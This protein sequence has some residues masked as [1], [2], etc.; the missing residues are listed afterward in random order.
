MANP[1]STFC[2]A[3]TRLMHLEEDYSRKRKPK[4]ERVDEIRTTL[5]NYLDEHKLSCLAVDVTTFDEET[6][7]PVS[8][9][10][11]L[12]ISTPSTIGVLNP[13][14]IEQAVNKVTPEDLRAQYNLLRDKAAKQAN[15]KRKKDADASASTAASSDITMLDVWDAIL[16][17]KIREQHL[18][19]TTQFRLDVSGERGVESMVAPSLITALVQEWV[20][21]NAELSQLASK[22][23][24]DE[25]KLE[26]VITKQEQ[27][28]IQHLERHHSA[29]KCQ[30]EVMLNYKNE[31]QP[32]M[33]RKKESKP[34]VKV[35]ITAFKP[36]IRT[37]L[38]QTLRQHSQSMA[39]FHTA[40]SDAIKADLVRHLKH[41]FAEYQ[42]TASESA[43][44]T[45]ASLDKVPVRKA[46]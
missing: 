15:K 13:E 5:R 28:V 17:V 14:G 32:Y 44:T 2:V 38:Q 42:R 31:S 36:Y 27:S 35:R 39:N 30:Q 22:K 45:Y 25:A 40:C 26:S 33:L 34:V 12:R 24:E 18:R 19:K 1:V 46:E 7:K 3:K 23:Q 21:L 10:R 43:K 8:C 41:N 29:S 37:S 20:N 9:R 16:A 4:A 6:G 11:Y